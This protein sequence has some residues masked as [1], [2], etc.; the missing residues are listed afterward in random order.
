MFKIRLPDQEEE[1]DEAFY[2]ELGIASK[3]QALVFMGDFNYPE[4]CCKDNTTRHIQSRSFLQSVDDNFLNTVFGK[5]WRTKEAPEDWTKANITPIF[6]KSKKENPGN[7]RLVSL[8]SIPGKVMEQLILDAIS[9]HVEEKKESVLGP[10]LFNVFINDLDEGREHTL[11]RFADDTKLGGGAD[12]PEGY[13]AIQQDLSRLE[14]WAL[15]NI[16]KFNKS[17]SGFPQLG[18]N[19]PMHQY[20]LGADL[21]EG[22]PAERDLRVLVDKLAMKQQRALVAK[23][24]N[25]LLR[26]IKK[27]IA[28]RLRKVILPLYS[29]LVRPHL[30]YCVPV[31][32]PQFKKDRKLLERVQWRCTKMIKGVEHLSYEYRL[33]D[34]SLFSLEKRRLRGDL[35]NAYKYLKGG[36]Q[37]DGVRL[38]SVVTGDRT[39][40]NRQKLESK[41]FHPNTRK[42]FFTLRVTEHPQEQA[43]RRRGVSFSGYIQ[44]CLDVFLS[45]LL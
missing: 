36:C 9:K 15:R 11:S 29:A 20:R 32:G 19:N 40:D 10:V 28:S 16:T 39:R 1:V 12:T 8:T 42:N 34:L 6:K 26:C 17:K 33:R 18:R 23:K 43:A 14:S 3:S 38:F 35:I 37:E 24:T 41:K 31:L 25:G 7:Y 21:L 2:R 27:S 45:N 44:T 22:R 13:A 5:S 30:E 4:I